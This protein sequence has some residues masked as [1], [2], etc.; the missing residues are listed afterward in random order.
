MAEV[1]LGATVVTAAAVQWLAGMGFA[2]VA[3]PVLVLVLGTAQGVLVAN[4]AAGVI[5]VVGLAAG[6]RRVRVGAMVPLIAA[7]ACTVPA[8]SWA[9]ARLPEPLLLVGVGSL[10]TL[11]VAFLMGGARL[12]SGW[13]TCARCGI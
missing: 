13:V 7:A 8:G 3:V 11:A 9:A 10:V 5:S 4:C 12:P 1:L 6:W 2:L